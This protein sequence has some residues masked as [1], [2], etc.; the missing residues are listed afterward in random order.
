MLVGS[1]RT[2]KDTSV[3]LPL[4]LVWWKTSIGTQKLLQL[5]QRRSQGKKIYP[6]LVN[7]LVALKLNHYIAPTMYDSL[8]NS[9]TIHEGSSA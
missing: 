7:M 3:T 6:R 1:I 2:G 5:L 8:V 4:D 9:C